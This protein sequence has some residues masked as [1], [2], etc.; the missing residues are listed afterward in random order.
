[1]KISF[2]TYLLLPALFVFSVS[3][4]FAQNYKPEDFGYRILKMPYKK[5]TVELVVNYKKGEENLRKPVIL[6]EKGSLPIPL[7]LSLRWPRYQFHYA[8]RYPDSDQGL[9]PG[10]RE[11]ARCTGN[12][13]R[14]KYNQPR[15]IQ[16]P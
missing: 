14:K 2:K 4:A 15:R 6:I 5:D 9:P 16:R 7:L 13:K 1:M 8:F 10:F 12:G 11:Q 3:A